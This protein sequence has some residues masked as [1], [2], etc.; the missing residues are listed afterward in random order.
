MSSYV[1]DFAMI[2]TNRPRSQARFIG[3]HK[4]GSRAAGLSSQSLLIKLNNNNIKMSIAS[5]AILG[6]YLCALACSVSSVHVI[7]NVLSICR[8]SYSFTLR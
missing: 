2:L 5:R 4:Y 1:I 3:D 8:Q 6:M 7:H